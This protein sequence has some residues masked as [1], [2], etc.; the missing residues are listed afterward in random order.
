MMEKA[1]RC[2]ACMEQDETGWSKLDGQGR[3]TIAGVF[4]FALYLT[5]MVTM[6]MINNVLD[7]VPKAVEQIQSRYIKQS[8]P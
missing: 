1:L 2:M 6:M 8:T 4:V 5:V 7:K 3:A